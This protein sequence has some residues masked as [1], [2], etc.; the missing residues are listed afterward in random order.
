MSVLQYSAP[1]RLTT[2]QSVPAV[3]LQSPGVRRG[4]A[5]SSA[6]QS[7]APVRERAGSAGEF[8]RVSVC[9]T[10]SSRRADFYLQ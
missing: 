8:R 6:Q 7:A 1:P 5:G 3:V 2:Q 10:E 9:R 4:R